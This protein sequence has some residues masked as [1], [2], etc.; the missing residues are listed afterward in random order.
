M[1]KLERSSTITSKSQAEIFEFV[2]NLR[3]WEKLMP[4]GKV[5]KWT[6]DA[7]NCSFNI[8][9]MADLELQV[10]SRNEPNSIELK[11][12]SPKP[13]PISLKLVL[14]EQGDVQFQFEGEMNFFL[15]SVAEKPLGNLFGIMADKLKEQL[16]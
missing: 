1:L 13:F 10:V 2:S 4:E 15:Q 11:N 14:S 3:N 8:N 6:A 5:T 16:D 7:D 12:P 9:N